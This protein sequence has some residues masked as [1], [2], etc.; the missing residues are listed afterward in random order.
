ME[1]FYVWCKVVL[2]P[3][4]ESRWNYYRDLAWRLLRTVNGKD[5]TFAVWCPAICTVEWKYLYLRWMAGDVFQFSC[6]YLRIR[7]KEHRM[8]SNLWSFPQTSLLL[9]QSGN[10]IKVC[11]KTKKFKAAD[12][13]TINTSFCVLATI[14]SSQNLDVYNTRFWILS[15]KKTEPDLGWT[16]LYRA[17]LYQLKQIV[18]NFPESMRYLN[19]SLQLKTFWL[20]LHPESWIIVEH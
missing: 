7:R 18:R 13:I 12:S 4:T 1:H 11:K 16:A 10:S 9:K 19:Y 5:E 3:S 15:P 2:C 8:R 20:D 14:L 17:R 6:D